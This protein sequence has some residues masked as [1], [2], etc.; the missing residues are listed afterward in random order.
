MATA[1]D[2][3]ATIADK[4]AKEFIRLALG[5]DTDPIWGLSVT[6]AT[7]V[8]PGGV[9]M[10]QIHSSRRI[11]FYDGLRVL[12]FLR[13]LRLNEVSVYPKTYDNVWGEMVDFIVTPCN[14]GL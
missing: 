1:L 10:V 14:R 7:G 3:T 8:S 12:W 2:I 11:D 4:I 9:Y 6:V 13:G 5:T